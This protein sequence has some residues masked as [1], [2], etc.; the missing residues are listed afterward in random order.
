MNCPE[1]HT[2]LGQ[3]N[4][5]AAFEWYECPSCE[6]CFTGDE[7]LEAEIAQHARSNRSGSDSRRTDSVDRVAGSKKVVAK[8]KKKKAEIDA[9]EE[10]I[11]AYEQSVTEV[12]HAGEKSTKHR[13]EIS[14]GQVVQIMADEIEVLYEEMGQ[15][16]NR[17]NAEDKA[18]TLWR[19]LHVHD[20]IVAREKAVE[21]AL[22]GEH[23]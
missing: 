21:L 17:V 13:D 8:A 3:K 20:G 19:N 1:C 16:L 14:T 7:I 9:D 11:A 10:A 2:K 6:G 5:D 12:I 4:Y 22:C 15:S 23:S 18:L